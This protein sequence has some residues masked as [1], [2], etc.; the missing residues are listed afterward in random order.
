[1]AVAHL[2]SMIQL[3]FTTLETVSSTTLGPAPYFRVEGLSLRQGPGNEIVGLYR[4]HRWEVNGQYPSSYE[5]RDRTQLHFESD[6]GERSERFGPFS[7][8]RFPNGSCYAD[9]IRIAELIEEDES[10]ECVMD[11]TRWFAIVMTPG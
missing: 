7:R 8:I 1:M 3:R 6:R 9:E 5:C 11:G 2:L 10:W 4:R